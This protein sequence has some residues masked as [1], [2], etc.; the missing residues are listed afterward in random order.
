V[1]D[2]LTLAD[3]A[4]INLQHGESQYREF[5]SALE[6]PPGNKKPRRVAD[7]CRDIA[8]A[9]V[10]F[11]NADGGDLLIG[12][13]DNGEVTG[14]PHDQSAIADMRNA[15]RTHVYKDQL[16]QVPY[17]GE[18]E[19]D[20]KRVLFFS[21]A[22]GTSRVYQLADGR[23]V[24]RVDLATVPVS[25]EHLQ[26]ERQEVRSR[27]YETQFRDG[28]LVSDLDSLELQAAASQGLS[29]E[30]YL[31]QAQLAEYQ[32]GG[33]RLRQAALLL[34]AK[35]IVR[36]H[37]RCEVRIL[38]VRGTEVLPGE[39]YNV[40]QDVIVAG[41][42]VQLART[43]WERLRDLLILRTEFD[44]EA[45]FQAKLMFPEVA[46]REAL[47]NAIAHRDYSITNPV[48]VFIFNDRIEVKSPGPLLSTIK[49]EELRQLGGA[50]ESRNALMARCLKDLKVM[51]ELGEGIRRIFEDME[52]GEYR[53]PD[54]ISNGHAFSVVLHGGSLFTEDQRRW[55]A[56]FEGFRLS[57]LQRRIVAAGVHGRELDAGSIR[58]AINTLD[59]ATYDQEVTGLREMGVLERLPAKRFRVRLPRAPV[60][61]P[62]ATRKWH[63]E[64]TG[65]W[66]GGFDY[67]ESDEAIREL[68]APFGEVLHVERGTTQYGSWAVAFL[69][70]E[71]VARRAI[72]LLHGTRLS[73]R[74]LIFRPYRVKSSPPARA[75]TKAP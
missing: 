11:A 47:T 2:L 57:R 4:R 28:A 61:Q 48:E 34:F 65:V 25:I 42:A 24:R 35:D 52:F 37:P 70:S 55:L 66:V 44:S 59:R 60:Q 16:L 69:E 50:H 33:L 74:D 41:C 23:C 53:K 31:Q 5:K 67:A 22:K 38:R 72:D 26:F 14:V 9:L 39:R 32:P 46:C 73:G 27:Q 45:K 21:A 75:I 12:V 63:P 40:A 19:I 54:L 18:V 6:G 1:D 58:D 3:R 71:V 64:A 13:E 10:G 8:E 17:S 51:R 68:F 7:I 49:I 62:S 56:Q 29:I 30:R 20:G 36:W 43:A 15:V